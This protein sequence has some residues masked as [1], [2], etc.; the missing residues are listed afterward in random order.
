MDVEKLETYTQLLDGK[1][2]RIFRIFM[3]A[4]ISYVIDS[5]SHNAPSLSLLCYFVAILSMDFVTTHKL[6]TQSCHYFE[7]DCKQ[8]MMIFD[9]TTLSPRV[10]GIIRDD[11]CHW[12]GFNHNFPSFLTRIRLQ[13][14][15]KSKTPRIGVDGRS[16]IEEHG[17]FMFVGIRQSS[18][19]TILPHALCH[20]SLFIIFFRSRKVSSWWSSE[21]Q[22]SLWENL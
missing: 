17:N 8:R 7:I 18:A 11:C 22:F 21:K 1:I 9:G 19:I 16:N 12:A 14:S 2:E 4:I 20:G 6:F 3:K 10:Y 13:S 15:S 5:R